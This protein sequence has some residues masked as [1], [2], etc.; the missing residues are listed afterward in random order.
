M[1]PLERIIGDWLTSGSPPT[2]LLERLLDHEDEMADGLRMAG[3]NLGADAAFVS[4]AILDIGLGR[5]PPDEV[6]THIN[7]AFTERLEFWQ[8]QFRRQQG[9]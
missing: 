6:V 3:A 7:R 5:R 1:S 9:D 4:K 2:A 8:E